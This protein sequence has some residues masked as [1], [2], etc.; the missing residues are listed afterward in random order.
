MAELY[1]TNRTF[2]GVHD[3]TWTALAIW[4]IIGLKGITYNVNRIINVI[5]NASVAW[6]SAILGMFSALFILLGTVAALKKMQRREFLLIVFIGMSWFL[7][8]VLNEDARTLLSGSFFSPVLIYGFCGI[9]CIS[10][11][12]DWKKFQTISVPFTI[13]GLITFFVLSFLNINGDITDQREL[14]YMSFSYQNLPFVISAFWLAIHRKSI[15]FWIIAPISMIVLLVT[16]SRGAFLCVLVYLLLELVLSKKTHIAIKI[17]CFLLAFL[18]FFNIEPLMVELDGVLKGYGYHSRTV[19]KF[20]EGTFQDDSGR[21]DVFKYSWEIV[22]E[23][24][25]FG[26]GMAGSMPLLYEKVNGIRP[27]GAQGAYS[28][29]LFIELF[30]HYGIFLGAFICI[31]ILYHIFR[32]FIRSRNKNVYNILFVFFSLTI[33]KLMITSTYLSEPEFF[34]LLGLMLNLSYENYDELQ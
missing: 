27:I 16:G 33:P 4:A 12:T 31:W 15:G 13:L 3:D 28:H 29:N 7:S 22:L 21:G 11:F 19:E 5:L 2:F 30:M 34:I 1:R 6:D 9:I 32:A 10:H 25:I 8:F 20:F 24:P 17:I 26:C 23:H 14:G 18:V